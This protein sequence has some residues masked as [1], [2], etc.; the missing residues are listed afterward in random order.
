[1]KNQFCTPQYENTKDFMDFILLFPAVKKKITLH[2]LLLENNL[3]L[4][5]EEKK[6]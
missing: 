5:Q 3:K 4:D 1:L 2:I 6:V